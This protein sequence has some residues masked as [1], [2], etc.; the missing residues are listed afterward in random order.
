MKVLAISMLLFLCM[1]TGVT[2]AGQVVIDAPKVAGYP[3]DLCREWATNCGK[4]AADA[5]CQSKGYPQSISHVVQNDSPT[6]KIINGGGLC[7]EA[8]CDRISQVT[9]ETKSTV[10]NN[11]Q[12]GG[13]PLDL[14]REWASNC[15]KPA[16]DAYCQSKGYQTSLNHVVQNDAP[17]TKIINGGG[18]CVEAYCDR[19]TQVTCQ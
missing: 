8:Y 15:G 10:I 14:C 3:L 18:L 4:P 1:F 11:P 19:I 13:Y 12:V 9:C 7:V 5:Y 6:T 17:T 2:L 16:A